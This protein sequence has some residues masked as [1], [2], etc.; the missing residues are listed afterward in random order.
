M[1]TVRVAVVVFD[2]GALVCDAA[3]TFSADAFS[4]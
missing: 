1:L 3:A 4:F 2:E